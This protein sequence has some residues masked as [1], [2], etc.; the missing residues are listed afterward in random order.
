MTTN[1]EVYMAGCVGGFTASIGDMLKNGETSTV[2]RLAQQMWEIFNKSQ[3]N[4]T[5]VLIAL[6]LIIIL[7]FFLC[8]VNTPGN[9]SEGFSRGLSVFA[10]LAIA[11]PSVPPSQPPSRPQTTCFKLFSQ[12]FKSNI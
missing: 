6:L 8:W 5:W 11:G 3:S 7:A 10:V 4:E 2:K 9:K 1:W 12:R